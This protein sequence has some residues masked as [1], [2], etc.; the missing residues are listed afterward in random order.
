MKYYIGV[1]LGGTNIAIGIVNEKKEMLLK[2]RH[3]T[4]TWSF[5]ISRVSLREILTRSVS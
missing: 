4:E 5:T 2:K 3:L 1:D